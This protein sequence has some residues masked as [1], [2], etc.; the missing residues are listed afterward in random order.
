MCL[1]N[2]FCDSALDEDSGYNASISSLP[3]AQKE[4]LERYRCT[5]C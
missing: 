3:R 2:V 4:A 5:I 1:R